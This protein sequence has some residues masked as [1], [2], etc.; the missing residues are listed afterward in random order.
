ML[1]TFIMSFIV[2]QKVKRRTYAYEVESYWDREKKQPRQRRRYL[3]V[4]DEETG[5]I[6]AKR[7]Q[8]DIRVA[9][10]Y[11]PVYLLD[12][13]AEEIDL[14]RKL[15]GSFGGDGDPLLALAMAKVMEPGSPRLLHHVLERSFLPE[16]FS[17][18]E[19]CTSQRLSRFIGEDR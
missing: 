17:I 10:D 14:R 2:H 18:R 3:G 11:G 13:I 16:L 9:K 15:A 19:E 12:R 5:E 8:R 7:F 1:D 4:V 6:V